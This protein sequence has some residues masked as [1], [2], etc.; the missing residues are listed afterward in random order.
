MGRAMGP[1]RAGMVSK[2]P[3]R[4]I[5]PVYRSKPTGK[6]LL[7]P[8]TTILQRQRFAKRVKVNW[9]GGK[10]P[11]FRT[12]GGCSYSR[13]Y[14]GT[15]RVRTLCSD[16]TI[17]DP[18]SEVQVKNHYGWPHI[19]RIRSNRGATLAPAADLWGR[20]VRRLPPRPVSQVEPRILG[21]S[22]G[23]TNSKHGISQC[24]LVPVHTGVLGWLVQNRVAKAARKYNTWACHFPVVV[25]F[26]PRSDRCVL[27]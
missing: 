17:N 23:F 11:N 2:R 25:R 24:N 20:G 6:W 5:E 18:Y 4:P 14:Y 26:M 15:L 3:D 9:K 16:R 1:P 22:A 19:S 12:N 27:L 8:L 21:C 7:Q 13:S 10:Q